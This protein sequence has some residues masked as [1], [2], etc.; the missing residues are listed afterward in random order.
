MRYELRTTFTLPNGLPTAPNDIGRGDRVL[1]WLYEYLPTQATMGCDL[2]PPR[3]S[4]NRYTEPDVILHV[5]TQYRDVF[6]LTE[7]RLRLENALSGTPPAV[8][9]SPMPAFTFE[10]SRVYGDA[11]LVDA[12]DPTKK[13]S[14]PC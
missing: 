3:W 14:H 9:R 4:G 2:A 8:V 13:I 5:V 12:P 6:A 11:E 10:V 1:H 7:D